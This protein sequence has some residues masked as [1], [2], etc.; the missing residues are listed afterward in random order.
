MLFGRRWITIYFILSN[1]NKSV[2]I[3]KSEKA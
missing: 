3:F 1:N 2:M